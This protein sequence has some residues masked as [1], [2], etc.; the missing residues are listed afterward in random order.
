[1]SILK[2]KSKEPIGVK[3]C[4]QILDQVH[5]IL[6]KSKLSLKELVWVYGQLGYNI[7]A[8][9]EGQAFSP[10]DATKEYYTSPRLGVALQVQGLQTQTWTDQIEESRDDQS[11]RGTTPEDGSKS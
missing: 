10:E 6:N 9:L 4:E 11:N 3:K 7:G 5:E 1:M 2:K 8:S